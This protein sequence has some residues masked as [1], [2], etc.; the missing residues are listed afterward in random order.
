MNL[1]K[2]CKDHDTSSG[3]IEEYLMKGKKTV[4]KKLLPSSNLKQQPQ[5]SV[6][7]IKAR[8]LWVVK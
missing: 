2:K 3:Y 6:K 5:D 7:V 4:Q 8:K 1:S